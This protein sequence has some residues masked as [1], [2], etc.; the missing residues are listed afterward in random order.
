M[1]NYHVVLH[2]GDERNVKASDIQVEMNGTLWFFNEAGERFMAYGPA[3]WLLV[4][5]E[6]RDDTGTAAT[7][8]KKGGKK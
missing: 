3:T 5:V 4:E 2:S 1:R 7:E 6:T 8:G